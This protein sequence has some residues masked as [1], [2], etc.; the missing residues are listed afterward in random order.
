MKKINSP[1][2]LSNP[3]K[4]I[5][6]DLDTAHL[7]IKAANKAIE[8]G[9]IN[10]SYHLFSEGLSLLEPF[11]QQNQNA[12]DTLFISAA[13]LFSKVCLYIGRGYD[14]AYKFAEKALEVSKYLGDMRSLAMLDLHIGRLLFYKNRK[15]DAIKHLALGQEAVELL[16]DDDIRTQSYEF[17]GL[18]YFMRGLNKEASEYLEKAIHANE[19]F[20]EVQFITPTTPAAFSLSLA[21]LGQFSRAIGLLDYFWRLALSNKNVGPACVYRS[22]LGTVLLVMGKKQE[23]FWHLE[24]ALRDAINSNNAAVRYISYGGLAYYNFLNKDYKE[25]HGILEHMLSEAKNAGVRQQIAS[26]YLIEILYELGMTDLYPINGYSFQEQAEIIMKEP[27]VHLKGV[28]LRLKAKDAML[29]NENIKGVESYLNDSLDYLQLSGDP[30]Q[31]AKTKIELAL[32]RLKEGDSKEAEKLTQDARKALSVISEEVFPDGLRFLLQNASSQSSTPA[33]YEK[34]LLS[35]LDMIIKSPISPVLE[36]TLDSMISQMTRLLGAERGGLFWLINA[37][38]KE[39]KLLAS[40][41]LHKNDTISPHFNF[42]MKFIQ[43]TFQTVQPQ[44]M[45]SEYPHFNLTSRITCHMLCLPLN[46]DG[47]VQAV[48]YFDN[49]YTLDRFDNLTDNVLSLMSH[50]LGSWVEQVRNVSRLMEQKIKVTREESVQRELSGRSDFI[51]GKSHAMAKIVEAVDKVSRTDSPVLIDGETGSG[52]ELIAR[53][54]HDMSYRSKKPLVI[55]DL[56]TIPENLIESELFGYEKG[57]FTGANSRK[58]GRIEQ[59]NEGTLYIDEIGEVPKSLQVKLLRVLQEKTFT[60]IGGARQLESDFRLVAATNRNLIEEVAAGRFREDLYYRLSTVNI[61][62]PPLRE[63]REDIIPLAS[64]FLS[65]FLKRYNRPSLK[66]SSSDEEKLIKYSWPGNVRELNNVIERAAILSERGTLELIIPSISQPSATNWFGSNLT[67]DE[68][69]R[70]YICHILEQT[71]GR[72]A[73]TG[74][75]AEIMGIHRSTL[76]SRMKKLGITKVK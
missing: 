23:A 59:A 66:L 7:R 32:L 70:H 34:S 72:I 31:L 21:Y 55:L 29:H 44:K 71:G 1:D 12:N 39:T 38:S 16:G 65:R 49:S 67:Y 61:T 24:G 45:I 5:S 54:I 3:Q 9:Q 11:L 10:D 52:K 36:E 2:I 48:L 73:G 13:L 42:G 63:R 51:I 8:E 30:V 46:I 47:K 56:T 6:H 25:A 22:V 33:V 57:A 53:R 17:I 28:V 68:M 60:R 74:G 37:N 4:N 15:R 58:I 35:Q 43:K 14:D 20:A 62:L 27:N 64:F 69:E 19:H 26:Y 18:Y 41:N 50:I 75:A 40:Q 76:Q